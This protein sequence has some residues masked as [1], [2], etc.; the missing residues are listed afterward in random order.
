MG[1]LTKPNYKLTPPMRE[2]FLELVTKTGNPNTAAAAIGVT[3][4][5]IKGAMGRDLAFADAIE[6]AKA[7]YLSKI[8]EELYK[9]AV[10]GVERE[11]WYQGAVV[12]KE[13]V[14]SDKLLELLIQANDKK[15][16]KSS[17]VDVNVNVSASDTFSKLASFLKVEEKVVDAIEDADYEEVEGES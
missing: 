8:E 7:V 3:T 12:G 9:R 5:C 11:V 4:D 16:T 10:T 2:H 6:M 17:N 1:N 14:K 15:Y 13:T